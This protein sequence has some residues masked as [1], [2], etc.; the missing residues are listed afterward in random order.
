MINVW[1][2]YFSDGVSSLFT[3]SKQTGQ[4]WLEVTQEDIDQG[5]SC[6]PNRCPVSRAVSRQLKGSW[7]VGLTHV[8]KRGG[9]SS[10]YYILPDTAVKFIC[11]YDSGY[12]VA[13]FI[14]SVEK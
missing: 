7:S 13:P 9:E 2:K 3:R 10:M 11:A 14:F 5:E 1:K 8:S 4:I 6:N 12:P